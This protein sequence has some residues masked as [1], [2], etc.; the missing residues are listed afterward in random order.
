MEK[1][2]HGF[3]DLFE[4]LGLA[5]DEASIRKFCDEHKMLGEEVLPDARFW[6][7][8][9][10]QFLRESWSQDADWAVLIDQLNASLHRQVIAEN[11]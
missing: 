8:A 4:Q 7:P 5:S 10:A 2:A 6:S 11:S 9:Q 3:S 1:T